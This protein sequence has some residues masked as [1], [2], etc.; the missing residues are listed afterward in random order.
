LLRIGSMRRGRVLFPGYLRSKFV[1]SCPMCT[2][3]FSS[4]CNF[5]LVSFPSYA[6]CVDLLCVLACVEVVVLVSGVEFRVSVGRNSRKTG[7]NVHV[8]T[9]WWWSCTNETCCEKRCINKYTRKL[10]RRK[11][12][13]FVFQYTIWRSNIISIL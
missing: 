13:L 2:S 7:V 8:K 1:V 5:Y 3:Y 9:A 6:C 4:N 12:N 10:W 11:Y